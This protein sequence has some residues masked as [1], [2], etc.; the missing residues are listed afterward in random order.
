[1]YEWRIAAWV[2]RT[3]G[4][5]NLMDSQERSLRVLEEAIELAQADGIS[6]SKVELLVDR[7]YSRPHG[8]PRA[9]AGGVG[10][11]LV[12]WA[13]SH[14]TTI[15]HIILDEVERIEAMD[16]ELPRAKQM[17]KAEA[18]LGLPLEE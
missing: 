17:D 4:E 15:E 1:M 6:R 10:V 7:V 2:K 11:T 12:A 3:F 13:V 8:A 9:E 5:K 14:N 18:G 16:P